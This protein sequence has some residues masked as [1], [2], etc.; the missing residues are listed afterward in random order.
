[1]ADKND[2]IEGISA[3]G[4]GQGEQIQITI[5]DTG[6][7][8]TYASTVRV[9][10]SAEEINIDFAGPI[11]PTAPGAAKLKVDHRM[12]MNPYAA[13]RLAIQLTQT[14]AAYEQTYG[15]LEIDSRKRII[16]QPSK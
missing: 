11:K 5:D 15:M 8:S 1:M 9:W 12:I 16:R 4:A 6:A 13:K 7:P 14:I 2:T 10:G 3:G